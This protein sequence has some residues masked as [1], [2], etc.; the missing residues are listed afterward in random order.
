MRRSDRPVWI[1]FAR[2]TQKRKMPEASPSAV[3]RPVSQLSPH[4]CVTDDGAGS[5]VMKQRSIEQ[6]LRITFLSLCFPAIYVHRIGNQ[7]K[8][9][10]RDSQRQGKLKHRQSWRNSAPRLPRKKPVY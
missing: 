2:P 3:T 5:A 4:V 1:F 9:I 6:K 7:L 10:E 8:S